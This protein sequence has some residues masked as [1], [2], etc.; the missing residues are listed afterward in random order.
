MYLQ[1]SV[2]KSDFEEER[3]DRE[4]IHGLIGD[5]E[6]KNVQVEGRA[7]QEKAAYDQTLDDVNQDLLY[8]REQLHKHKVLLSEAEK[9]NQ[10]RV[11][12]AQKANDSAEAARQE[13]SKYFQESEKF[14]QST[15]FWKSEA[16]TQRRDV[17]SKAS[18]VKQYAKEI[19]RLKAKVGTYVHVCMCMCMYMYMYMNRSLANRVYWW[20]TLHLSQTV[21]RAD[22]N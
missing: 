11:K 22:I 18:Q 19:D 1:A 8:T 13:A 4:R 14:R 15:N 7:A 9:Q 3:R 17:Q 5:L 6:K 16:E 10:I 21:K 20:F 12:E 2:Y